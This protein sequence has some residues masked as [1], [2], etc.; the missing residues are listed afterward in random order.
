MVYGDPDKIF[1]P[2][3]HVTEMIFEVNHV[4]VFKKFFLNID[5]CSGTITTFCR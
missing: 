3:K 5:Y 2:V 4:A 1:A